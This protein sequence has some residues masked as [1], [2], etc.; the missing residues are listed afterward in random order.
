MKKILFICLSFL[1]NISCGC[2]QNLDPKAVFEKVAQGALL[3]DV[4]SAE[5]FE[6]GHL[7]QAFNIPHSDISRE[8]G[9]L[10]SDK[11]REVVLYCK[12]GR[13]ADLAIATLK[14]L[15]FIQTFNAGGYAHLQAHTK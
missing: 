14:G 15:G 8:I 5:E 6:F 1:V 11:H 4:R 2:A 3:V 9:K 12:S 10:G 13:R 7:E